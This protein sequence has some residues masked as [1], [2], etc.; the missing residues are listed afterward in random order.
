MKT[1]ETDDDENHAPHV[2]EDNIA[3]Q[4]S[5]NDIENDVLDYFLRSMDDDSTVTENVHISRDDNIILKVIDLFRKFEEHQTTQSMEDA[6]LQALFKGKNSLA[7][8]LT[9]GMWTGKVNGIRIPVSAR[10]MR[11][12]LR[13]LGLSPLE[14]RTLCFHGSTL[15]RPHE[16]AP[17]LDEE[18]TVTRSNH[19]ACPVEGCGLYRRDG[20]TWLR[21]RLASRLQELCS[22]SSICWVLLEHY[23]DRV[24][25]EDNEDW[26]PAAT[27][28]IYHGE[29]WQKWQAFFSPTMHWE[30]PQ[31]CPRCQ[32]AYHCFPFHHDRVANRE[33]VGSDELITCV[34]NHQFTYLPAYETGDPRHV[35]VLLHSDGFT[36]TTTKTR[37][38]QA[39]NIAIC[40]GGQNGLSIFRSLSIPIGYIPKDSLPKRRDGLDYFVEPILDELN[41]LHVHG[42]EV[43]FGMDVTCNGVVLPRTFKQRVVLMGVIGDHIAQCE[44]TKTSQ[45]MYNVLFLYLFHILSILNR[46]DLINR[47]RQ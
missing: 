25:H 26:P 30:V 13:T 45:G 38:F 33:R 35:A 17:I 15:Q 40:N 29:K 5:D 24:Q 1:P 9:D 11:T 19:E 32:Q 8:I 34:C 42:H 23:R 44:I 20:I 39:Y 4:E 12:F 7:G 18:T 37:S 41:N 36:Y 27:R 28:E 47:H 6:I 46:L 21:T 16:Y 22:S 31:V 3:P 10:S 14:R 2:V 43:T